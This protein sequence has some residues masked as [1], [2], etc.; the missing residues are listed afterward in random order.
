MLQHLARHLRRH[1]VAYL[2]L[3]VA[4]TA[5]GGAAYATIPDAARVIHGCYMGSGSTLRVIDTDVGDACRAGETALD[6]NQTGLPGPAGPAGAQGPPGSAPTY[7]RSRGGPVSLPE[8]GESKTI[9]SLTVPAGDYA[10][11]AKAVG[12]MTVPGYTCPEGTDIYYCNLTHNER[13][14]AAT[15]VGCA[16]RAGASSDLAQANLIAGAN[17]LSAFQTLSTGLVHSFGAPSNTISLRCLQYGGGKW[18]ARIANVRLVAMRVDAVDPSAISGAF[19]AKI[20]RAE[21]KPKLR[22]LRKI[23]P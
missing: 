4:T 19:S 13:R 2:A 17:L 7:A 15:I 18:P 8:P 21:K 20:P 23:L 22:P 5:A 1:A 16:L 12:A 11:F 14:L 6:W 9:A 3:A 10:I